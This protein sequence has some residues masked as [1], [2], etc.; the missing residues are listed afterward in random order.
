MY[1]YESKRII[2]SLGINFQGGDFCF[3]RRCCSIMGVLFLY[4]LDVSFAYFDLHNCRVT[5][6]LW[7]MWIVLMFSK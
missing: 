2:L 4:F 1:Q 5:K 3:M 7:C 6:I